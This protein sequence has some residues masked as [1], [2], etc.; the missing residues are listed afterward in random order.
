MGELK[1]QQK[2]AKH[3]AELSNVTNKVVIS[4]K[5]SKTDYEPSGHS[6]V[7]LMFIASF[8]VFSTMEQS[9]F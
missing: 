5:M 8:F 3:V 2:T 9:G 7:K 6:T 1:Q 4:V